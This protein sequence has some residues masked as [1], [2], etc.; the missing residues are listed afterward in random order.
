[1]PTRVILLAYIPPSAATS[2]AKAGLPSL[3]GSYPG[4]AAPGVRHVLAG[5]HGE[6]AGMDF[7]VNHR[8][9]NQRR[10]ISITGIQPLALDIDA[11]TAHIKSFQL[12]VLHQ[13][14]TGRQG[15]AGR[16]DKATAHGNA[17][18]VGNHHLGPSASDFDKPVQLAGVTAV[19]LIEDDAGFLFGQ[20]GLPATIPLAGWQYFYDCY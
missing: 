16:V 20:P 12:T 6:F 18:R 14:L 17:G 9:G 1:M 5:G 11:S 15:A 2:R 13:N 4:D 8:P 19:D 3:A 10:I 7:A